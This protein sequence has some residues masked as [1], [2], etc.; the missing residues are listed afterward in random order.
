M[1]SAKIIII[2][3]LRFGLSFCEDD[4]SAVKSIKLI[5]N[6]NLDLM[7]L[8]KNFLIKLKKKTQIVEDDRIISKILFVQWLF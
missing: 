4:K 5:C 3:G 7:F 2:L 6:K 1:S 8:Y